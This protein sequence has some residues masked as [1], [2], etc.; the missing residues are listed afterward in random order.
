MYSTFTEWAKES[1]TNVC[2]L[3]YALQKIPKNSF[4]HWFYLRNLVK[5]HRLQ[6]AAKVARDLVVKIRDRC[7]KMGISGCSQFMS[8]VTVV[9]YSLGAHVASQTCIYLNESTGEKVGK[10]IGVDPAAIS[11]TLKSFDQPFISQGDAEYVQVI[12]V[13]PKIFGV[14]APCADVDVYIKDMPVGFFEKHVYAP[15]LHMAIA[16]KKLV[17]IA[18][19]RGN[20]LVFPIAKSSILKFKVAVDEDEIVV[21]VYSELVESKRGQKFYLS[22]KNHF[23]TVRDGIS[24]VVRFH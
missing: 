2:Y 3:T 5:S 20:G 14:S 19:R 8:A 24:N 15:A 18:E 23:E 22:L 7:D 1:N 10:L 11:G 4:K 12:H 21:G 17:M 9:G 6:Y 13:D 16:M